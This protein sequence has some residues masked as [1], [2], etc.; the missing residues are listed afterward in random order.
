[1]NVPMDTSK[2]KQDFVYHVSAMKM[3]LNQILSVT[4]K[5]ALVNAKKILLV[6]LVTNVVLDFSTSL[7][8]SLG[9]ELCK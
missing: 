3:V 4:S 9:Y 6:G 5:L 7:N 8:H 1:M 2:Q